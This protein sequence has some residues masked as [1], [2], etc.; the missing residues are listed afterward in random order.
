MSK[1]K[2]SKKDKLKKYDLFSIMLEQSSV[3]RG[4]V[5]RFQSAFGFGHESAEPAVVAE[6]V[7]ASSRPRK[8][9]KTNKRSRASAGAKSGAA[10]K[11]VG[12][13]M[14][15][16]AETAPPVKPA[17]VASKVPAKKA[18]APAKQSASKRA[19][20]AVTKKPAVKTAKKVAPRKSAASK[21]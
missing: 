2:P 12:K 3:F 10:K 13:S 6:P 19:P 16:H 5:D 21:K 11:A 8:G 17:A 18:A 14:K 7:V 1:E 4:M 9:V 20:K 15:A